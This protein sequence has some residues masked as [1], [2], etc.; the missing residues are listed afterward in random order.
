MRLA[1][2]KLSASNYAALTARDGWRQQSPSEHAKSQRTAMTVREDAADVLDDVHSPFFAPA[3]IAKALSPQELTAL[4]SILEK[5]GV[6]NLLDAL[7]QLL[8]S[9]VD[10]SLIHSGVLL[11]HL[12][13][14]DVYA[15]AAECLQN[16]TFDKRIREL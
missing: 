15:Y 1:G 12:A 6:K 4:D 13:R 10:S 8:E 16:L 5:H 3:E 2:R 14:D 11:H 9:R 7:V